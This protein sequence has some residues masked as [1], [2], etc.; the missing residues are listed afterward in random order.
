MLRNSL[1]IPYLYQM[2][3][4][5]QV[6]LILLEVI[7]PLLKRLHLLFWVQQLRL[8]KSPNVVWQIIVILWYLRWC[9]ITTIP[10]LFI[11]KKTI[12]ELH[13]L[14]LLHSTLNEWCKALNQ[15]L[16]IY[17]RLLAKWNSPFSSHLVLL[18]TRFAANTVQQ[19]R[20]WLVLFNLI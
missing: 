8:L 3:Q 9:H 12:L 15:L 11:L 18:Q 1:L 10:F 14:L 20:S 6:V 7:P 13:W 17:F 5:N 4:L 19:V 16:V 2:P